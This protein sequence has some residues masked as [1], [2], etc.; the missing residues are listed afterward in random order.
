MTDKV[1]ISKE[2]GKTLVSTAR[3]IVTEYLKNGQH[4]ELGQK[5][6][7][8][9]SF[10][11][12]VFV[13]LNNPEG[14]RG[15]I[16]YPLPDKKLFDALENAAIAAATEDPRFPPVKF[17]E[18]KSITFEV[19]VLTPPTK[20][21]VSESKEYLLKIKIGQDGLIVKYGFNSGLLLPQVPIEYGWNE[22]EYLEHACEKAG[23][24]KDFWKNDQIEIQKFEGIVFKEKSPHGEIIQEKL[25][26]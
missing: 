22:R 12:G 3:M 21:E 24:P 18:L 10:N 9:F 25:L 7:E 20:I 4:L 15:C 19:T 23:L 14:L 1:K 16:G 6:L 8:D 5:I 2:D 17:D 26:D 11:S 13:T